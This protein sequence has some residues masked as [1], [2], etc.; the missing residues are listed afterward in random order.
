MI[1]RFVQMS[2]D[3]NTIAYAD[4]DYTFI[5]NIHVYELSAQSGEWELLGAPL[6][7]CSPEINYGYCMS[8]TGR[9][10]VVTC[11]TIILVFQYDRTL[12]TWME[13]NPIEFESRGDEFFVPQCSFDGR[14]VAVA[15]YDNDQKEN[16]VNVWTAI[17]DEEEER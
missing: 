2:S 11:R 7:T 12:N 6:A 10:I 17:D 8:G 13:V 3:G 16:Y 14:Q 5:G 1:G 4:M 15:I 9:V